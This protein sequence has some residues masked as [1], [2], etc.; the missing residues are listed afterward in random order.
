MRELLELMEQR[1]AS[2]LHVTVGLEPYFRID[3]KISATGLP[4]LSE[5][6]CELMLFSLIS[7]DQI[8]TFKERK[9]L[10]CSYGEKKL[11]RFRLNIYKQ[12]GTITAAI[13][14]LPLKIPDLEELGLPVDVV[15]SLCD[16]SSGL[17]IVAGPVGC[18]KT[19][20]VAA[21]AQYINSSRH[22]HI[23]SI[24]DPIE[25]I[26]ENQKSLFHQRELHT[27][28]LSFADALKYGLREDPDVI[29]VGEM[30]DLETI[31]SAVS[32]AETGHLVLATL[33]TANAGE[34]ISRIV[35]VFSAAQQSQVRVQLSC[36]L[37]GVLNQLLLPTLDDNGRVLAVEKMIATPAIASLIRENKIESIY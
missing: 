7:E 36:S 29:I 26:H 10:D 13:R 37:A 30:R 24:E 23:L 22:C 4:P 16:R 25:Y 1:G 3:G 8:K 34:S 21:M 18:G 2:D 5:E 33:H 15:K 17:V 20:T 28:T 12:R 19:T 9:V 27:D 31:S 35:D 14:R 32:I 6:D 11:G